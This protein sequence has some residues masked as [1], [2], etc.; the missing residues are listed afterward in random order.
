MAIIP[1]ERDLQKLIRCQQNGRVKVITGLRRCG[2]TFLLFELFRA[3]LLEQGVP[4][5][6][7][8]CVRLDLEEDIEYRDPHRLYEHVL[9][10]V[11]DEEPY[12]VLIDEIQN[13]ISPR[14]YRDIEYASPGIYTVLN[15]FLARPNLDVYVTGSNSRFLSS[16][17]LTEF[18]GRGT[19]IAL[20]PLTFA[21][22]L[23]ARHALMEGAENHASSAASLS[24]YLMYGGMPVCV[25][26]ADDTERRAYLKDLLTNTYRRDII[27]RYRITKVAEMDA[28]LTYLASN[29]GSFTS[30]RNVARDLKGR[31]GSGLSVVSALAYLEHLAESFVVD[32][33]PQRELR[34]R[35]L[36]EARSKYYFE[37]VGL[38]NAQ[39]GFASLDRGHLLE[40]A[41]YCELVARGFDVGVGRVTVRE[42]KDSV[43]RELECDFV[44]EDVA[45]A[46]LYVQVAW[47][48]EGEGVEAR[49]KRPLQAIADAH[50]K[51]IIVGD[52]RGIARTSEGIVVLGATDFLTSPTVAFAYA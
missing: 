36:L 9:G 7:I 37:D 11:G 2:K 12:F 14:E 47:T 26:E 29:V 46:R 4:A 17:V 18:R 40:N 39:L 28:L 34:G 52:E 38:R 20:R 32:A 31:M 30:G 13:A 19:N 22:Y 16:D 5:D 15:G 6:H 3:H 45:N 42:G 51:L 49:E 35:A 21:E 44:A 1:R 33:V 50:S 48:L 27:E 23:G 24:D 8:I 25:L 10:Q 43:R 41:V